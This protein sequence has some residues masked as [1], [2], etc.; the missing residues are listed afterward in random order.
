MVVFQFVNF[1]VPSVTS[2]E[3]GVIDVEW[4]KEASAGRPNKEEA[5]LMYQ[6]SILIRNIPM[7]SNQKLQR[8]LGLRFLAARRVKG[9]FRWCIAPGAAVHRG[10]EL[11]TSFLHPGSSANLVNSLY[12][13]PRSKR[14]Q[15]HTRL[16]SHLYTHSLPLLDRQP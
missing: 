5:Y 4:S 7:Y 14:Q 16:S 9:S 10:G 3:K 2:C 6:Y 8:A 15:A 12:Q 1:V 11:E 13:L